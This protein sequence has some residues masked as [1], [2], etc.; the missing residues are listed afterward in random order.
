MRRGRAGRSGSGR[1]CDTMIRVRVGRRR[2]LQLQ[3]MLEGVG[4]RAEAGAQ[5]PPASASGSE[6]SKWTRMKKR[7]C[8]PVVELL[9]LQDV[10][11]VPARG[12]R[13]RR[14]RGPALSG[15]ERVR[16]YS[17]PGAGRGDMRSLRWCV[18]HNMV[19]DTQHGRLG[20]RS[21]QGRPDAAR[22]HRVARRRIV[23][24]VNHLTYVRDIRQGVP[25]QAIGCTMRNGDFC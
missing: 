1:T 3:D 19:S 5:R 13:S 15:H 24:R 22:A 17:R 7:P 11:G 16:T 8:Q 9:A 23:I 21:G 4:D 2:V 20:G 6:T 18:L 12:S 25:P 10:A 14:G